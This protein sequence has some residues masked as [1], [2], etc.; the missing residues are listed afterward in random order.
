M[1]A[2]AR[3]RLRL[4]ARRAGPS[5]VNHKTTLKSIIPSPFTFYR[6]PFGQLFSLKMGKK[7]LT[8]EPFLPFSG[9]WTKKNEFGFQL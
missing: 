1:S 3:H 9:K 4:Q 2:P 6:S 7:I 5:A 8:M